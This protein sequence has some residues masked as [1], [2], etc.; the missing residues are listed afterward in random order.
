[1]IRKLR[2]H[3]IGSL[4]LDSPP[5][6][7]K[8]QRW[9]GALLLIALVALA[10]VLQLARQGW[11]A[12]LDTLWAEDGSIFLQRALTLD[13]WHAL[14]STYATYLVLAPS[15]IGELAGL[16][17]LRD[18]AA[19]TSFLAAA[20]VA[21]CGVT[22]WFAA[23][24]HIRNPYLRGALVVL[25]VLTPVGGIE[26]AD[27]AAYVLWYMLFASFWILLWR[28]SSRTGTAFASAFV[29]V[30]G[31]STPG[32]LFLAPAAA[33]RAAAVRGRR[34]V[35][36]LCSWA[37]GLAIQIPIVL[38]SSDSVPV[39]AWSH[40][41]WTVYL[42]RV[43]VETWLGLRLG[44]DAWTHLGVGLLVIAVLACL[45]GLIAGLRRASEDAR[46][47]SG[48]AISS[49][50]VMFIATAYERGAATEMLWPAGAYNF[51]G[52]RYVI[53]PSLLLVSA[54]L[55]LLD[56]HLRQREPGRKLTLAPAGLVVGL[57]AVALVDSFWVQNLAVR[58]TPWKA[59][60]EN[61]ARECEARPA[62]EAEIPISPP[63]WTM[64]LPCSQLESL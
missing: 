50:L 16:V 55:V 44:G 35:L 62:S 15:L 19:A 26:S 41:V 2:A 36:I 49:S 51:L 63:G 25:T 13:L 11:S 45:L 29:L 38:S 48:I 31:L 10:I 14:T 1:L 40:D 30:T 12:S 52:S 32:V 8:L 37:A 20:T 3:L 28:P 57:L 27:S 60:L 54:A 58:G 61:V 22:I 21:L 24:G 4:T 33:L 46:W 42:Q 59:T 56:C 18:A 39:A 7:W 9:E 23:A 64:K 6:P 17:P 53:V 5:Q 34:D 43:L 47:I